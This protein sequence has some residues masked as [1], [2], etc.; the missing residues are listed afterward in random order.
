[1]RFLLRKKRT[2]AERMEFQKRLYEKMEEDF[3]DVYVR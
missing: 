2:E 1:V 3:M